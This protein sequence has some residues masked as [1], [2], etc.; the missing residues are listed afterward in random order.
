[1]EILMRTRGSGWKRV[2]ETK[3]ESEYMLQKL[4]YE[5]PEVIPVASW[6]SASL[7]PRVF[8]REAGLP[9]SG[10]SDLI[11]V[12]EAGGITIIEC[13]LA[14][15][16]EV[17][18]KVVG[19]LLE[20]AAYLWQMTYQS[21]DDTC[22]RAEKWPGRHLAEVM[23][24]RVGEDPEWSEEQFRSNVEANLK[25]GSFT[26]VIAVD[27]LNDQLR[28]II[29]YLNSRGAGAPRVAV[30]EIQQFEE[31]DTQLLVPQVFGS[32]AVVEPP[33]SRS[34]IDEERFLEMCSERNSESAVRLYNKARELRDR[35]RLAGA[36]DFINWGVSGYSYR[37]MWPGN[38]NGE[39][40]FTG[41]CDNTLSLWMY[42]VTKALAQGSAYEERL[43]QIPLI[44]AKMGRGNQPYIG[45]STMSDADMDRFMSAID[46]LGA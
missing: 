5:S 21:F 32:A 39:V 20:Y 30:L 18:R 10:S 25:G 2:G 8:I 15:N 28:R 33:V 38:A 9:G 14:A 16:P 34:R 40:V 45:I 42:I 17:R 43:K 24:E 35:R 26:L 36:Q 3:F 12:D 11:G 37:M 31:G 27:Q 6:G 7:Q 1:M 4:I 41:S 46:D 44:A 23:Q 19:Q 22:C 29:E 13:K